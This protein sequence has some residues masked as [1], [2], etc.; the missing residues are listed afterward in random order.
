LA[1]HP[2]LLPASAL[3]GARVALSVS[4]SPDLPRLG[5]REG[6]LR[7]AVGEIARAV[8]LGGGA[9]AYGGHLDAGGFTA[10][11]LG[12]LARYGPANRGSLTIY[13][14]WSEHRRRAL[15]DLDAAE[16]A[17]GLGGEII[18]LDAAGAPTD[19]AAGRGPAPEPVGDSEVVRQALAAMRH[20]MTAGIDARVL[21]GGRRQGFQGAWPGLVQETVYAVEAG[22]PVYLAGGFGGVTADMTMSLGL[23]PADWFPRPD[24]AQDD[25]R[26]AEALRALTQ[27][28]AAGGLPQNGLTAEET[29]RLATTYRPSEVAAFAALG[30][31]RLRTAAPPG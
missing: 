31:G 10:F 4:D 19:R 18:Y 14:A 16:Q 29:T 27:A 30:L 6:H 20:T 2:A 22:K 12:E 24:R 5:L 9:L 15:A 1:D 7:T 8:M 23:A 11:L 13:L 3:E 21:I 17:L 28:V 26:V 25:P